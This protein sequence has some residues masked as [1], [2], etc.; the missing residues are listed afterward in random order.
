MKVVS[1]GFFALLLAACTVS[2]SPDDSSDLP[3]A[4]GGTPQQQIEAEKSAREFLAMI[5]R[6]EFD[7]TW[8]LAGPALRDQTSKFTWTNMLKLTS[9]TLAGGSTRDLEGFGFSTK[10]DA[11]V[12]VGDYVLVQFKG[13]SDRI[14]TTEKVVMQRDQSKWKIIGYFV[15]KRSEFG[16]GT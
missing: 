3:Q 16:A 12:P 4:T 6:G 15:T 5:D 11:N 13:V 10:I 9:K 2:F 8:D 14:T 1:A 7:R